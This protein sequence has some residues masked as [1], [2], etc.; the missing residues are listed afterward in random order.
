MLVWERGAGGKLS[1]FGET[2][3]GTKNGEQGRVILFRARHFLLQNRRVFREG[4]ERHRTRS[5]GSGRMKGPSRQ[6]GRKGLPC[7]LFTRGQLNPGARSLTPPVPR[8]LDRQKDS[9]GHLDHCGPVAGTGDWADNGHSE[10]GRDIQ[11]VPPHRRFSSRS[12][13]SPD[14]DSF[15]CSIVMLN[16]CG[17]TD[18]PHENGFRPDTADLVPHASDRQRAK[19]PQS[20]VPLCPARRGPFRFF[21]FQR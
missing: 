12:P 13:V 3:R 1:W 5:P 18:R 9:N 7:H 21:R 2:G 17:R 16:A 19:F 8:T 6:G 4:S 10:S 15:K 20:S 14:R 11:E